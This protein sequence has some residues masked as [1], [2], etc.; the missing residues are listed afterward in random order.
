MK[1]H[2]F[3][4]SAATVAAVGLAGDA[5]AASYASGIRNT[6]GTNYEFILNEAASN[7]TV[8][9]AGGG[10]TNLGALGAGRHTFTAPGAFDIAVASSSTPG[11]TRIDDNANRFTHFE[12]PG[13]LAVNSNPASP[14][15]GTVYVNV[16][17]SEVTVGVPVSTVSG[18]PMGNG[19]YSLTADRNGVN[20][21]DWTVPANPDDTSLAKLPPGIQFSTTSS[22]SIYRIG[23]D[24]Y[25]NLL[26]ADWT[27][28]FGGLKVMSADLTTGGVLLRGEGGTRP[29]I[30]LSDDS[31]EFGLLP[32]HGSINGKPQATGTWGVDLSVAAM[33]EDMDVDLVLNTADD[34]NSVWRWNIGSTLTNFAGAPSLEVGVGSL[35]SPGA[36]TGQHTD[37]TPV[38]LNLNIGVTAN[39]IY[40]EHFDKWYLAGARANGNDSSSLVILTPE[41]PGGDGKDIV[42]DWS[43]KQFSIDNGLDGYVDTTDPI[44]PLSEDPASD[45]LR[46]AHN[47]TFSPDN[48]VM[49]VQRRIVN[50]EN[51]ILGAT[52]LTGLGAKIL[53]IQLDENGLPIIGVDDGG[54]PEDKTDDKLTGITPIFTLGAQGSTGSNS[55]IQ[56]D[57]AGNLY[58][59]D[60]ISERLEYYRRGG[61][62]VA[63]TSSAGTFS[64]EELALQTG[65]YNGDGV[66]DA[67][68]YT[69][70]RDSEGRSRLAGTQTDGNGNGIVD[71]GDYAAWASNYGAP[72]AS[73]G[74]AVP[75][76]TAVL[77][78][79]AGLAGLATRSRR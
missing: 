27:D 12:R 30:P 23:M 55:D 33:D 72:G 54:T 76:P 10:S 29:N 26:L 9:L 36:A 46:Q 58:F 4:I 60:N 61:S 53:A 75:E 74:A 47:V 28:A 1:K 21:T 57:A 13:G 66:I 38:F 41:G 45:I 68:D 59:S 52:S 40:N 17:R 11:F 19:V 22:S 18:R 56:T 44:E 50:G 6:G 69:L 63:T 3:A 51:P 65:D 48:T 24:D 8:N 49:Y 31:D 73:L 42:V 25:G 16:N 64:I 67:A 34:G 43:S 20:L 70:W 78:C 35:T 15:F 37:G 7:V 14:Y 71:S 32:L 79:L 62:F 2:L 5:F 39:A 77:L